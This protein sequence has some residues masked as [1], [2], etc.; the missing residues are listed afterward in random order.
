MITK[1]E[2]YQRALEYFPELENRTYVDVV[3]GLPD[4][5]HVQECWDYPVDKEFWLVR[6]SKWSKNSD[7][8]GI[9]SSF[10]IWVCK[11]TGKILYQ[12]SLSDEG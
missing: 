2:A 11:E 4:N 3:G 7:I 5:A 10:G 1:V 8:Q 6:Y 9:S 12:D